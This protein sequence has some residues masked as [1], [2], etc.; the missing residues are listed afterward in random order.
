M[1]LLRVYGIPDRS[2]HSLK[3]VIM[4][5]YDR[6]KE[7]MFRLIYAGLIKDG[8]KLWWPFDD[9]YQDENGLHPKGYRILVDDVEGCVVCDTWIFPGYACGYPLL[10]KMKFV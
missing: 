4:S 7:A 6:S 10:Y 3:D 9:E 8:K 5:Q 2:C 1:G